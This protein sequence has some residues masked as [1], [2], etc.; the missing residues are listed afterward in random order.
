MRPMTRL[1]PDEPEP[2]LRALPN[3][4]PASERMLG[5]AGIHA[6]SQLRA[7][8]AVRAFQAVRQ[9]GRRP[10]LNLLWALE[11]ALTGRDWKAVAQRERTA[12]LMQL[13]DLERAHQSTPAELE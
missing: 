3:L 4:G 13:D 5:A 12:L 7:L 2:P 1:R 8:G 6:P 9:A 10:S 11:G